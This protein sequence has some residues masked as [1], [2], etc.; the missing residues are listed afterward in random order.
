LGFLACSDLTPEKREFYSTCRGMHPKM[1]ALHPKM[2]ALHA[3]LSVQQDVS[4]GG[5]EGIGQREVQLR[6]L[7][8]HS[9]CCRF[10]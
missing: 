5:L 8:W 6:L 3:M 1:L 2:L 4:F 9:F 7:A 10:Y